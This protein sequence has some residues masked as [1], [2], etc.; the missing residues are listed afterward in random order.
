M[1]SNAAQDMSGF[2]TLAG[3]IPNMLMVKIPKGGKTL[4]GIPIDEI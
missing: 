3:Q 1:A 2:V 4:S